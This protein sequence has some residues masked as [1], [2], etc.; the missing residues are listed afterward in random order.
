MDYVCS[1]V[2][3]GYL[4]LRRSVFCYVSFPH[5]LESFCNAG[6]ILM[7]QDQEQSRT[8]ALILHSV[9]SFPHFSRHV[10]IREV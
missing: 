4:T 3:D 8:Y 6:E 10:I 7:S 2:R 5:F 9:L 1:T